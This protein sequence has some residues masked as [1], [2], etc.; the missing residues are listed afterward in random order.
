M[1]RFLQWGLEAL[2]KGTWPESRHDSRPWQQT[3]EKRAQKSGERLGAKACLVYIKGDWAEY[4]STV[5]LPSWADKLRPCFACNSPPAR[6]HES[7]G[8]SPL[9]TPWRENLP[10]DYDFACQK[11]EHVVDL[12]RDSHR[13]ILEALHYDKRS[14]GGQGRC[15]WKPLLDLGLDI[16]DRLVPG[17]GL[18]DIADFDAINVFPYP[19]I[20]WRP[21]MQTLSKNRNPIFQP[22][23]G[24]DPA[25]SLTVDSLHCL[26]LGVI[27]V[28]CKV[29]VHALISG[30]VFGHATTLEESLQNAAI[31]IRFD[32]ANFL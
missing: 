13:R 15:L 30:G 20:F 16:G 5:G 3:D 9:G 4:A 19:V 28:F 22:E 11:C 14:N 24:L 29:S 32:L 26:Y 1:W 7:A 6:L 31:V 27:N 23:Y 10:G 8:I 21:R 12:S 25:T 18:F 17:R 2:A